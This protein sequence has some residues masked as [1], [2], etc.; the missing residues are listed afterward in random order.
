MSVRRS[1]CLSFRIYVW[2]ILVVQQ[3]SYEY[4]Y[5]YYCC[6]RRFSHCMLLSSPALSLSFFHTTHIPYNYDMRMNSQWPTFFAHVNK[7]DPKKAKWKHKLPSSVCKQNNSKNKNN[8]AIISVNSCWQCGSRE[9]CISGTPKPPN[10]AI[11]RAAFISRSLE[12]LVRPLVNTY[13]R[14]V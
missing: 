8:R 1:A 2:M 6:Y 13:I 7:H 14:R 3:K 5:Y 11:I 10:M 12:R 9:E 4:Y